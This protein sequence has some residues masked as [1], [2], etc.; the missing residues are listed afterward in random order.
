[1]SLAKEFQELLRSPAPKTADSPDALLYRQLASLGGPLLN[2][3]STNSTNSFLKTD[4]TSRGSSTTTTSPA[5]GGPGLDPGQ[6]GRDPNGTAID[7]SNVCVRAPSVIEIR[8]PAD[9]AEGCDFVTTGSL[10]RETGA[11]GSVQFQV[12]TT[13][14]G[15]D[16]GLVPS[17]V[18]ESPG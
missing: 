9:L 11:E 1:L 13:R 7:A 15:R 17:S 16:S 3:S 2:G 5:E 8:L 18:T 6:F 12:T 14:P 4:V 10:H